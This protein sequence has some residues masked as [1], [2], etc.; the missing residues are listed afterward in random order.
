MN[1]DK[2]NPVNMRTPKDRLRHTVLFEL[3]LVML[4]GPLLSMLLNQPI[5]TMGALTI[6]L[7][8]IAM[9]I[10]YVY[11][12]AFDHTLKKLGRP[13]HKRSAKLRVLHALLFELC[14]FSFSIP[15]VIYVLEYT[16]LEALM[17]DLGFLITVP[18][19]A[20]FFNMLYDFIFPP[21]SAQSIET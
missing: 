2:L 12:L 13:I 5:H 1:P 3:L 4:I 8:F 10:N 9:V 17:L 11:N 14:L 16:F 7:S 6:G 19:Y 15:M 20:F 18:I 21:P